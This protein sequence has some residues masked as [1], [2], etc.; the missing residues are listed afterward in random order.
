VLLLDLDGFK[1]VNDVH[2]HAA[3]DEFGVLLLHTTPV[4]AQALSETVAQAI[5]E[6]EVH[7]VT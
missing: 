6:T 1:A 3:G 7:W 2:G 4:T 5:G